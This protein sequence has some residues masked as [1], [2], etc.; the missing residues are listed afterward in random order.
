[1]FYPD[2]LRQNRPFSYSTKEPGLSVI[3]IH[4]YTRGSMEW[5]SSFYH[6]CTHSKI[7]QNVAKYHSILILSRIAKRSICESL[8]ERNSIEN[9]MHLGRKSPRRH[10]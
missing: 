9:A 7:L 6:N 5:R 3:F 2:V 1:M 8:I 4:L 10:L